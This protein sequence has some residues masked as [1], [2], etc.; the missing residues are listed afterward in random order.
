[1]KKTKEQERIE[2]LEKTVERL[3]LQQQ[4][5]YDFTKFISEKYANKSDTYG[6]QVKVKEFEE[7]LSKLESIEPKY[8]NPFGWSFFSSFIP[9]ML[10]LIFIILIIISD[11]IL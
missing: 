7:K 6:L 2:L 8:Y 4:C 5:L 10:F 3:N 9:A 1:M 11:K